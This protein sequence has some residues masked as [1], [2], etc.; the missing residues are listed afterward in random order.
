M[1]K[2]SALS[3]APRWC[4][5]HSNK[6]ITMTGKHRVQKL[7]SN[8][9]YCSR[10]KAE[11]LIK[12]GRVTVNGKLI[13]IGTSAAETDVIRV[14]GQIVAATKKIVIAFH[15]PAGCVTALSDK[16]HK[17]IMD[18]I[19]LRERVFPVGRL[20]FNT[21]GLLLLTNDGDFA[22]KVMHPRYTVIKTY[23]A[24]CD[25]VI[26][27]RAVQD[28][29]RGMIIDERSVRCIV[30]L[31]RPNV[32]ELT[33]HEGRKHIVKRLLKECGLHVV[34]LKRT[35][36]GKLALG[37]LGVGRWRELNEKEIESV[38]EI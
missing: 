18:Y 8:R 3:P 16:F 30:R 9:G 20:D 35:K 32:I 25:T 33:L 23:E 34:T 5:K 14:D 38:H 4:A 15:K 1:G 13:S 24:R 19:Q 10:R 22:N 26:G 17:T 29:R 28:I 2:L 37:E 21:S 31:V 11:E 27:E 6:M 36:I 7:L 12:Q